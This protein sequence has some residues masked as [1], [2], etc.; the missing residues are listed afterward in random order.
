V[1]S[2]STPE[3]DTS[4]SS[5]S[6]SDPLGSLEPPRAPQEE[7][8]AKAEI[9]TKAERGESLSSNHTVQP[10]DVDPANENLF[11]IDA[12][13]FVPS[14]VLIIRRITTTTGIPLPSLS[15]FSVV[16]LLSFSLFFLNDTSSTYRCFFDRRGC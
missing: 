16:Q 12:N 8:E 4:P 9:E 15:S 13:D 7:D 10:L 11:A 6:S 2:Q 3:G 1:R 14:L 5:P